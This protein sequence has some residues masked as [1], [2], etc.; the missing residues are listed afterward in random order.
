[1]SAIGDIQGSVL[2]ERGSLL[3]S[4]EVACNEKKTITLFD[5]TFGFMDIEPGTY[6]ITASLKGFKSQSKTIDVGKESLIID[7]HLPEARGTSRISGMVYD[8]ENK[9]PIHSGTVL[10]ILPVAN[11][12]VNLHNG[13][14]GFDNLEGESYDIVTSVPGYEDWKITIA[15]S[16]G[17]RKNLDIFCKPVITVEPLWG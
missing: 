4:A 13:Y 5:G 16:E 9:K 12:Y 8:A 14:Y 6:T 10:L 2:S 1:M 11:R 17:E 3:G 7:F 15:V